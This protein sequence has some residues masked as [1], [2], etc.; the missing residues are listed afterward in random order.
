MVV[1]V[2]GLGAGRQAGGREGKG[3][4]RRGVEGGEERKGDW[5]ALVAGAPS[6]AECKPR[7]CVAECTARQAPHTSAQ[8]SAW[9]SMAGP[10]PAGV[11]GWA[12]RCTGY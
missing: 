5:G 6:T 3:R 9:A 2:V 12:T 7:K 1:V 10:P 11:G 4:G 8:Q